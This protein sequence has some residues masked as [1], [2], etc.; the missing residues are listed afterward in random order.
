MFILRYLMLLVLFVIANIGIAYALTCPPIS[1][2]RR[3]SPDLIFKFEPNMP[4]YKYC[5]GWKGTFYV[6]S[7]NTIMTRG[8]STL[9]STPC[10]SSIWEKVYTITKTQPAPDMTT[11]RSGYVSDMSSGRRLNDFT[12]WVKEP[13]PW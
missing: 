1:S 6:C 11:V 7:D 9:W 8:V 12:L 5:W 2:E 13:K 4:G 3:A 10:G